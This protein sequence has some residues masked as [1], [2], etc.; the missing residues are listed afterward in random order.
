MQSLQVLVASH[1]PG[2]MVNS[3]GLFALEGSGLLGNPICG[4]LIY[5]DGFKLSEPDLP[6]IRPADLIGVEVYKQASAPVQFRPQG[7][8]RQVILLWSRWGG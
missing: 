6:T 8:Y 1:I 4:I 5:L 2:I 7:N 3:R